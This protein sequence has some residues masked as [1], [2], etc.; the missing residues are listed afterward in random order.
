MF[1]IFLSEFTKNKDA[2]SYVDDITLDRTGGNYA[3]VLHNLE[4]LGYALLN[5]FK[6]NSM[7]YHPPLSGKITLETI[8]FP[9][10]NATNF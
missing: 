10:T 9:A 1:H 5:W 6:D 7:K 4:V 2:A 8:Q 3:F